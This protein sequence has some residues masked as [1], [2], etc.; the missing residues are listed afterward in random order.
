MVISTPCRI[1]FAG[2]VRRPIEEAGGEPALVEHRE[3]SG[4]L[5]SQRSSFEIAEGKTRIQPF[6]YTLVVSRLPANP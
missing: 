1:Q 3:T 4:R 6:S 2:R 5:W